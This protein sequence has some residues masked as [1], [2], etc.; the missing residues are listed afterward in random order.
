MA[1]NKIISIFVATLFLLVLG[2]GCKGLSQE[3]KAAVKP[4]TLT[5]WTVYDDMAQLQILASQYKQMRPYVTV[6]IRQVR[7]DEFEKLFVNALA[8]DV[9]PDIMSVDVKNLGMYKSRLSTMP[10]SVKM[11]RLLVTGTYFKETQVLED[12]NI[13]PTANDVKVNYVNTVY[14]DAVEAGQIY[15]LPM[16][17]DTLVIYYNKD[18]LDKA[19]VP[20]S[21]KTW[22]DFVSAVKATTKFDKEGKLIQSG[23]ALGTANNIEN[24]FDIVSLFLLQ[25]GVVMSQ[26]DYITFA[27]GLDQHPQ[28]HPVVRA[29]DF[30][31][32]FARDTKENY[33]WDEK[34]N[35]ALNQFASGKVAFYF[36]FA[37]DYS[38]IRA[39]GPQMNMDLIPVPQLNENSPVNVANYYLETVVKKSKHQNEAWDF[40][41]YITSPD[42]VAK[43]TTATRRPTPL[44]SQINEQ[45]KDIL[46]APFASQVLFS[47]NWYHGNNF[48]AARNAV[49]DMIHNYLQPYDGNERFHYANMVIYASKVIQQT[50]F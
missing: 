38:R 23:V 22:T 4:V 39:L 9:P 3:Q 26:G 43:Y 12:V 37:Y 41:R 40:V 27:S 49:I 50:M 46:L 2:F 5:F 6:N 48:T 47:K 19:G 18:L 31:T 45:K 30:Y 8:D 44:R 7:A 16:A 14:D 35:S 10:S 36:G 15:G 28:D 11:A 29:L 34:Q 21:P 25:S 42:S 32:D 20:E 1:K 17:L 13:M 24:A 33:S